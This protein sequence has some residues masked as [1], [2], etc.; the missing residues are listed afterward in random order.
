M[1][2]HTSAPD[3]NVKIIKIIIVM[4]FQ[5]LCEESIRD[6]GN[7]LFFSPNDRRLYRSKTVLI[8][9]HK[10]SMKLKTSRNEML[11]TSGSLAS[12]VVTSVSACNR[13]LH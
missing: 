7:I 9:S 13:R 4:P 3:E 11:L 12:S 8:V 2:A 1:S 5:Q 10:M 6:T